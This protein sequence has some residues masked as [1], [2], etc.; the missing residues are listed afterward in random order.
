MEKK[1]LLVSN[2]NTAFWFVSVYVI[3]NIDIDTLK[4]KVRVH[5]AKPIKLT[6]LM[7]PL[8]SPLM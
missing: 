2:E 3:V 7:L 8:L 5:G 6:T 4:N 1:S